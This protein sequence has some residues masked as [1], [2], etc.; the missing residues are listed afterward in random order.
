VETAVG[1]SHHATAAFYSTTPGSVIVL[2]RERLE[3]W[4]RSFPFLADRLRRAAA[5]A[6][7]KVQATDGAKAAVADFF[8]RH[9]LSVSMT[10]RVRKIDSCIEC[11]ACEQACED[12]YG[13]KRLSLNGRILG[14]LD[15][16]DACHTC[17]DA[18]CIDPCNFDA[19]SYDAE[20]REILIKEDACTGCTMCASACPYN[21]IEM[22]ELD[23]T[24]LLKLRLQ[25][26]KKLAHGEGTPRKARLRRLASKCDH[27]IAYQDQACISACPTGALLEIKPSDAVAEVPAAA[28]ATARAGYDRSVVI[29]SKHLNHPRAFTKGGLAVPELGRARA[30]RSQMRLTFWWGLGLVAFFLSC[31]EIELRLW[32]PHW[33]LQFVLLTLVDGIDPQLALDKVGFTPGCALATNFGYAGTAMM[34]TGMLYVWRRRFGFM[35]RAGSLRSWFEWHVI[36]GVF[37]PL[38]ILLHS[39]GKLDNWVSMGFWSMVLTVVSGLLGRYLTTQLPERASTAAVATLHLGG[40]LAQLRERAPGVR[41]AD[42]WYDAYR[43]RLTSFDKSMGEMQRPHPGRSGGDKAPTIWGALRTLVW[44]FKDD[45]LRGHRLRRLKRQLRKAVHGKG[46]RRTRRAALK[47]AHQLALLERRRVLLPRL[48]PLFKQWYAVHV[49]MAVTLTVIATLHIIHELR[50]G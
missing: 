28:R 27:C 34:I 17:S 31:A 45:L 26:E 48:E 49:P 40:K 18:R 24:P 4:K 29:H 14:N 36:T 38:F 30:P 8:I 39:V 6:H 13:V 12:R 16:V 19:I 46:A 20:R 11:G 15:L 10:L 37:G 44:L 7:A 1:A 3:E 9:G 43:R 41:V 21:A 22:H 2:G 35:R 50:R 5:L 23:E 33:S 42:V 47:L 25:K 32:A